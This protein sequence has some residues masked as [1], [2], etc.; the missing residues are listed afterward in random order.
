[1]EALVLEIGRALRRTRIARGLTLREAAAASGG[2]FQATS[3]AGY[4]RGERSI[5]LERF[6]DLCRI[7]GMAPERLLADIVRAAEGRAEPKIDLEVLEK[8]G[9]V[10]G[11]LISGFVREVSALR[12]ERKGDTIVLRAGDLE[13]L[14]TASGRK[15]EELLEMLR[16]A[17]QRED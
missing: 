1:L 5:S 8:L 14:A 7:Y 6:C 11:A 9:S 16:P 17:L 10:E 15:P 4:E 3:V 13:V 2:R 12:S